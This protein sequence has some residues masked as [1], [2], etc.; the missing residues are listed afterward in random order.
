MAVSA[1]HIAVCNLRLSEIHHLQH[2]RRFKLNPSKKLLG[3]TR[4][5]LGNPFGLR[6]R[7][8]DGCFIVRALDPQRTK[9]AEESS[10]IDKNTSASTFQEDLEYASKLV[11][12]SVVGAAAI[13]YGSALFPEITRPNILLALI[14]IF[15]PVLVVVLLLIK[16]SRSE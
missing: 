13:K 12:G 11:G 7:K 3:I 4:F 10:S 15:I 2:Q 6:T 8:L 16:E 5:V 1:T 9:E 14:M